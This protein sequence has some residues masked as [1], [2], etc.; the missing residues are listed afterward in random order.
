MVFSY[1]GELSVV[2]RI[3]KEVIR[4]ILK[5]LFVLRFL[6]KVCVSYYLVGIY[7]RDKKIGEV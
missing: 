7:W 2:E 1:W 3:I 4:I 6:F 5:V